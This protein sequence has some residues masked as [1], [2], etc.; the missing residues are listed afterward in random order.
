[1]TN[2]FIFSIF[3]YR[4]VNTQIFFRKFPQN[5]RIVEVFHP[6]KPNSLSEEG[7]KRR[8]LNSKRA[9]LPKDETVVS[10][11]LYF[12]ESIAHQSLR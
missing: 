6:A 8:V 9:D 11:A 7:G 10:S 2:N 1:L 12:G 5:H 3:A 4:G